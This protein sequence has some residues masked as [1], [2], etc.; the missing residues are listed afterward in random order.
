[1]LRMFWTSL[2]RI[3]GPGLLALT[4]CKSGSPGR[5]GEGSTESTG[6]ESSGETGEYDPGQP[7]PAP[8]LE[9][10][11]NTSIDI[12]I[13]TELCWEPVEDPEGDEV[14]YR[15][16]VDDI[17]LSQGKLG[18]DGFDGPCTGPLD[19][20][21]D[22][23]YEWEVRAFDPNAPE[24][25]SGLSERWQFHTVWDGESKTLFEDDF[26]DGGE[27][28]EVGG[29]ASSGAWVHGEPEYTE[30]KP[31]LLTTELSQPGA[32]SP[33]TGCF[34]TG[35]NPDGESDDA[36]VSGGQTTLTS[37]AFDLTGSQSVVV[38]FAR[39]FYKSEVEE[40]GSWLRVEL[41][42]PDDEEPGGFAVFVL[43]QLEAEEDVTGTNV[44]T[45]IG[46]GT[47]G[48]PTVEGARL[49]FVAQDL[50]DGIIEAAIDSVEVKGFKNE[51]VCAD[52]PGGLCDPKD[53]QSCGDGLLCCPQGTLN[54]GIHR[55]EEPVLD[56]DVSNPPAGPADPNNGV[57]GC[58]APDLT[59]DDDGMEMWIE[60]VFVE[61]DAC[62][63]YE[64][65][66]GG[67]GWRKLL[68]FDA[69]TPN[70]GSRDLVMG[71]PSNHPDLYH[72]SECH[73]HYHFDGYVEYALLD[74]DDE[75]SGGHK[76][77]FCLVDWRSWAWPWLEG[78]EDMGDEGYYNCFN[79]GISRGWEDVY[80]ADLE[81]QWVDI[82]DVPPGDYTL[83]IEVNPPPPSSE[84][85]LLIERNYDNNVLE[86]PVQIP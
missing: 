43:D 4:A 5:G 36:D 37:R 42:V 39:F 40:F 82:T 11:P 8:K 51:D 68:R 41:L 13:Q 19:L 21:F 54:A 71:I 25:Q 7:P 58:D 65:C 80:A 77:A 60:D 79:Q 78:K 67:T 30:H 50:G 76:Q 17:E 1:M 55:C 27:G 81:C 26:E 53:P 3:A 56:L 6:A 48:V 10:P 70:L 44:W 35:H 57:P 74:G 14:R 28:W 31:S 32:C 45:P 38:S 2:R 20:L 29:D 85:R 63:L 75:L 47:C 34:F 69:Q 52:G 9:S 86:V 73:M 46:L 84:T 49:R 18:E 64:G 61:Q 33:G 12:P 59:V 72:F 15:V 83:R 23:D 24:V 62:T 66:V 16:Y 22:R